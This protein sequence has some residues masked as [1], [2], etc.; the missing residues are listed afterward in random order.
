[1]KKILLISVAALFAWA[2]SA[3][4]NTYRNTQTNNYRNAAQTNNYRNA[5]QTYNNNAAQA[6]NYRGTPSD[7]RSAVGPRVN[8]YTNTDDASVG[9]GAY[10]RYSFNSHWRIEPSIYVLTEKDSSVDINFDAHYVF[11]IADWW[12]VFPQVGIVANDIK[13]WAVGMSVGAGFDFNV[14]HRWNISAGPSTSLCLTATV[15][16]RWWYTSAPRTDS[17][18]RTCITHAKSGSRCRDP[19]FHAVRHN[20]GIIWSY[21]PHGTFPWQGSATCL[22][23]DCDA[24]ARCGP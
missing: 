15:R 19:L 1:M 11:Q 16:T 3:Q 13:D 8:F 2:A 7:Y 4:D 23:A 10:Y 20:A 21:R 24:A 6:G 18:K 12:G 14:A 17:D 9:I 5:A 22:S